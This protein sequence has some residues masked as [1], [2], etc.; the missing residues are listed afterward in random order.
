M[1]QDVVLPLLARTATMGSGDIVRTL[2]TGLHVIIN[3]TAIAGGVTLT[4]KVRGKDALGNAYDLLVGAGLTATGLTVLKIV[5]AITDAANS[6][7][8]DMLP[9][10]YDVVMT[11]TGAGAHT[12]SVCLNKLINRTA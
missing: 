6:A 5:P 11:Q 3:I 9:D 10:V 12:Y 1:S 8:S 7:V 2:E 4:P